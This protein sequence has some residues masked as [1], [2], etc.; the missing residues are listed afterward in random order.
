[1]QL[2]L[3]MLLVFTHTSLHPNHQVAG[4]YQSPHNGGFFNG[5]MTHRQNACFGYELYGTPG[6]WSG[7][8]SEVCQ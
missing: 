8:S 2:L 4:W 1:M 7:V 3:V 5:Y 6:W